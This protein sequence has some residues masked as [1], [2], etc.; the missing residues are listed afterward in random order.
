MF[1]EIFASAP[2]FSSRADRAAL[3]ARSLALAHRTIV[4]ARAGPRASQRG[5][6]QSI[7][8]IMRCAAARRARARERWPI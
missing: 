8:S 3:D 7:A 6:A 2:I 5:A 1:V 4:P